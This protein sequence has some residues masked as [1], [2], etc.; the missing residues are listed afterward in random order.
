MFMTIGIVLGVVLLALAVAIMTRPPSFRVERSATIAAPAEVVYGYVND[1]HE[2]TQW[3]PWE[4][5]DPNLKRTFSG[6]PSGTGAVYR[7]VG[8]SK[9]GEG[10]MTIKESKPNQRIAIDLQFLKPFKA[11]NLTEFTFRPEAGG[12]NLNWAMSGENTFM[13]KAMTLVASMD[14]MVGKDFEK[15]LA[16]LKSVAESD[17][18]QR[19]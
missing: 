11:R 14:K 17:A 1:F 4:K 15:G 3:S 12:V 8:N 18:K 2:W 19:V 13:T 6:P 10:M 9:A 16:N 5:L 7:W